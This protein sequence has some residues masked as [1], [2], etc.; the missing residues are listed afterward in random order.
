M[1][2]GRRR[3]G[4]G[5]SGLGGSSPGFSSSGLRHAEAAI[6]PTRLR[7][8]L[9]LQVLSMDLDVETFA[10]SLLD[11]PSPDTLQQALRELSDLGAVSQK[12]LT[13][14]GRHL[15]H[16][17]CAPRLGK[18]LVLGASLGVRDEALRVAAGLGGRSPWRSHPDD[19]P[20]AARFRQE[21][22]ERHGCGRSDHALDALALRAYAE[23][24]SQPVSKF[25]GAFHAIDAMLHATHR[26]IC[27]QVAAGLGAETR[28]AGLVRAARLERGPA[29]GRFITSQTAGRRALGSR[30]R[31]LRHATDG[32]GVVEGR[33]GRR[34]RRSI[35]KIGED[36][37]AVPKIRRDVGRQ[38]RH[39]RASAGT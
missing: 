10:P 7:V 39:G 21:L 14:L 36:R 25:H 23:A 37:E 11:P 24:S 17:P 3:L 28:S 18:L 9:C 15:A 2:A 8:A 22:R 12:K 30:L 4:S 34:R 19:R 35:P 31:V 29:R 38:H 6:L 16:L 1:S 32:T 13:P 27:A 33:A 5:L 20:L 26:S